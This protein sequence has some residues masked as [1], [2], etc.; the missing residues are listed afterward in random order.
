[1]GYTNVH[2]IKS[3][4]K[5]AIDYICDPKKTNFQTYISTEHC[6][7]N[8][9]H[10]MFEMTKKR[11]RSNVDNLAFHI[12]QSFKKGEVTPEQALE[13]G[14]ETMKR[15]LGNEYEFIIAT[16]T[17]TGKIHNHIIVNS[18]N[19]INGKSFSREHD[20]KS[21]P[22]WLK[23]RRISDELLIQNGL[24][25]IEEPENK[26]KSHYEWSIER[27]GLS[28]KT[29]LKRCI[30]NAVKDVDSFENF[31]SLLRQKNIT[32]RYE[33]YKTKEGMILAFKME[34]QK[35]FIFSKTLG[36]YY[37][38]QAIKE[39]I[40]RAVERKKLNPIE[41]RQQRILNDDGEL[42]RLY[43]VSEMN[44]I[45]LQ[46]WAENEN[47]KIKMQTLNVLHEKG[48]SSYL[49]LELY[50]EKL[51]NSIERNS[52]SYA[53]LKKQLV[54]MKA[55]Q[56][57]IDIY[58][59]YKEIYDYYV[60]RAVDPDEYFRSHE[61]EILLFEEAKNELKNH[62]DTVP[63]RAVYRNEIAEIESQMKAVQQHTEE[64]RREHKSLDTLAYNLGIIYEDM[65]VR[66]AENEPAER[67]IEEQKKRRTDDFEIDL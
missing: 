62:F 46:N 5:K 19:M 8:T 7:V 59:D 17:D 29:Q 51:M 44:G 21:D 55:I 63:N 10:R 22:A 50:R 58:R 38:E 61:T 4:L 53:E 18:V 45:G 16:H 26:G 30:D 6:G 1:M 49:E 25:I 9:A 24:S 28:W 60:A 48:F 52:D 64:L 41:R 67:Q 15:F 32:V 3:T 33:P 57:Y 40:E 31:I 47:R 20:R 37:S 54:D 39:R 65:H 42:K 11:H 27:Q 34:G 36:K 66:Q 43:D 23:L 35:H 13:I 56:N 14:K 2:S 12:V